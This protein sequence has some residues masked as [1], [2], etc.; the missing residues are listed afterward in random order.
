MMENTGQMGQKRERLIQ[1]I[2]KYKLT[3]IVFCVPQKQE[4]HAGLER[5][6]GK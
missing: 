4:C 3:D 1:K 2:Y 6:E 5:H